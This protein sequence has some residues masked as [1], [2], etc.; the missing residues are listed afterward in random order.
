[1]AGS[2]EP[3]GVRSLRRIA[4]AVRSRLEPGEIVRWAV[5][6]RTARGE[7]QG[8]FGPAVTGGIRVVLIATDRA[9][10]VFTITGP[11]WV[12]PGEV[13][14]RYPIADTPVD[15]E[16]ERLRVGRD[17]YV[18]STLGSQSDGA[19]LVD[20]VRA[21]REGAIIETGLSRRRRSVPTMPGAFRL[22]Q[23]VRARSLRG[24]LV[25][26]AVSFVVF[27]ALFVTGSAGAPREPVAGSREETGGPKED[28]GASPV[29]ARV[30]VL[31]DA[32]RDLSY[33]NQ[34][35]YE[36]ELGE[37]LPATSPVGRMPVME[38]P[39]GLSAYAA[40]KYRGWEW[41]AELRHGGF[42]RAYVR[43]WPGSLAEVT[44]FDSHEEALAFHAWA[45]GFSCAYS[46]DVFDVEGVEGSTGLRILYST[47]RVQE[48]VSFVR[49]SRRYAVSVNSM[50]PPTDHGA[51]EALA[52]LA[53]DFAM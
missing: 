12:R 32:A 37:L 6:A 2:L 42:R 15:L 51:V 34:T 46:D 3:K 48:R 22:P 23:P 31:D 49:G 10:C 26:A 33:G 1:M 47:G 27:G 50:G 28:A 19:V 17:G 11:H 38:R 13:L 52:K 20:Y 7:V 40:L 25:P 29:C 8:P 18:L 39:L 44:E 41:E 5:Y 14:A 16:P 4:R 9:I 43:T 21:V 45:D 24:A 53:D 36:G 30:A 35:S